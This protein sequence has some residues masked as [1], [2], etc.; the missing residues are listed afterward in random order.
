MGK[1]WPHDGAPGQSEDPRQ[2][3]IHIKNLILVFGIVREKVRTRPMQMC[4]TQYRVSVIDGVMTNLQSHNDTSKDRIHSV[5]I[6]IFSW[7]RGNFDPLVP[8]N[9]KSENDQNH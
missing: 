2:S 8:L 1:C 9:L 5:D 7:L 6:E 3:L 4:R